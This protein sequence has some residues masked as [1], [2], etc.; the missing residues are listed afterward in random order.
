MVHKLPTATEGVKVLVVSRAL[1]TL[2]TLISTVNK[3]VNA[4]VDFAKNI[5]FFLFI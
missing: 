1:A 4:V 2:L 3:D 5:L